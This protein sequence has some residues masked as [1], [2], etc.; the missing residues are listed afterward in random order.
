MS[1]V[2]DGVRF[3]PSRCFACG[4]CV[5]GC[6]RGA[7]SIS[8]KRL[9]MRSIS[10]EV[11]QHW[12]VFQQSGGGEPLAQRDFLFALLTELHDEGA[13]PP[14]STPV[15]KRTGRYS[16]ECCRI[17]TIDDEK[18]REWTGSGNADILA[19]ARK[20]A[21]SQLDILVRVP[22]IPGFNDADAE[23]YDI[24]EFLAETGLKR[25]GI[26]PYHTLGLGKYRALGKSHF[27]YAAARP[28]ISEA[29]DILKS[30]GIKVEVYSLWHEGGAGISSHFR[31]ARG[32][33][34]PKLGFINY[35]LD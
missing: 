32:W 17:L 20:L 33:L 13:F 29:V 30:V 22:L 2:A 19:N 31:G 6:L 21:E 14:A 8:G 34:C 1:F 7:R 26:M 28:R 27:L 15:P 4:A 10:D 3:D 24:A 16:N 35:V 25:V 18:H 5:S 11:C 9:G 23:L 12:R